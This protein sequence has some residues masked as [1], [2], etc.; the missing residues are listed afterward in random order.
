MIP[1]LSPPYPYLPPGQALLLLQ[2]HF[3]RAP[4]PISDYINDTK[5]VLDQVRVKEPLLALILP[6]PGPYMAPTWPLHGP[7]LAPT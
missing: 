7:Y 3:C 5:T 2:A 1:S 6:L 4:L